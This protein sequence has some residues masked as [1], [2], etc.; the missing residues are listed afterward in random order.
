MVAFILTLKNEKDISPF[1]TSVTLQNPTDIKETNGDGD[2]IL[3]TPD[4]VYIR[5][6][7]P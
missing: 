1:Y 5:G 3:E 7:R 6:G 4:V 2:E